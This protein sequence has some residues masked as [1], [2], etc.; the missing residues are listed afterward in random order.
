MND[1][2]SHPAGSSRIMSGALA[3]LAQHME[4][5]CPRSAY[6]A[7]LLL[8]RIADDTGNAAHLRHPAK[9]LA[10]LIESGDKA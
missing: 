10:D 4:R 1:C 7:A 9:L 6:L 5:A 2:A 3:Y 8:N